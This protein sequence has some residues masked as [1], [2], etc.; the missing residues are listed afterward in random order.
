MAHSSQ[1][2]LDMILE[3]L[4]SDMQCRYQVV[5]DYLD[6]EYQHA[7]ISTLRH[8]SSHRFS[9]I[10][11]FVLSLRQPC[12]EKMEHKSWGK[13][14]SYIL[15]SSWLGKLRVSSSGKWAVMKT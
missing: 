13:K 9:R 1:H 10:Q 3:D 14:N 8:P 15:Y 4:Q 11:H 6:D 5:L 12:V 2:V 7:G